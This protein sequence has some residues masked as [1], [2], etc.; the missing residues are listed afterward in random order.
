MAP[1]TKVNMPGVAEGKE[2]IA[3]PTDDH[4]SEMERVKSFLSNSMSSEAD[5]EVSPHQF[6]F[7][8]TISYSSS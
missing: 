4:V 6:S 2:L 7:R 1:K 8:I 3:I 5:D